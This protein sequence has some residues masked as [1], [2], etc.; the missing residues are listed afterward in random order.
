MEVLV[1]CCAGEAPE[2]VQGLPAQKCVTLLR[3]GEAKEDAV[4]ACLT[5][6][7]GLAWLQA[8]THAPP[9]YARHSPTL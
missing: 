9:M 2:S 4:V 6:Q 3:Y 8:A 5:M 7:L 1:A